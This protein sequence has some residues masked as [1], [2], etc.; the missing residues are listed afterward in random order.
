MTNTAT[1]GSLVNRIQ[2]VIVPSTSQKNCLHKCN[3]LPK[4]LCQSKNV[5]GL[6]FQIFS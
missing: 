4:N 3:Y 6:S 5:T 2:D 1:S